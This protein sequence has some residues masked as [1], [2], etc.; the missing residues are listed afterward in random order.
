MSILLATTSPILQRRVSAA[1]DGHALWLLDGALP[2]TAAQLLALL[3][4]TMRPQLV[5]LDASSEVEPAL[6]LAADLRVQCANTAVVL[7]SDRP[8]ELGLPALRAGVRD[9][10]PSSAETSEL[11]H[12]LLAATQAARS[13]AN[14]SS[15]PATGRVLTVLSPKG[16]V[17]KTTVSTN[18]AVGLAQA[19]PGSTVLV[20]LDL[21][22]G[23]I[24]TAL[25]L[26]AEYT[27]VDALRGAN[28]LDSMVLKTC[29]TRHASGLYVL[30]APESPAAM[31]KIGPKD[32]SRLLA[33]LVEEFAY[34]VVDTPPGL[35]E[36]TL[37]AIEQSTDQVLLT[38]M[39]VPGLWGL[40]KELDTL[41]QL[42][43][44]KASRQIV[45]N[46]ADAKAGLSLADAMATIGRRADILLPRSKLVTV[47]IN[48]GVPLLQAGG[49]DPMRKQL[50]KMVARFGVS[51]PVT[52]TRTAKK[53]TKP[54][55]SRT[56]P[57]RAAA[58]SQRA[59]VAAS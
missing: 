26:D 47:S 12:V 4:G 43:L 46:F 56:V 38:S 50:R 33:T 54:A 51:A 8:A 52:P 19:A 2:P 13:S 18:L 3:K 5:V 42:N 39:D 49:R 53:V 31:D 27:I 14:G 29:L 1:L 37:A 22:F 36:H 28:S 24:A 15:E 59:R 21:Q 34:V 41:I 44:L 11:R 57:R 20:D 48:L 30:P 7:L 58:R 35:S 10:V 16:G 9:I 23:D 55:A 32:V 40:R 45:L 25:N 17:G 6:R